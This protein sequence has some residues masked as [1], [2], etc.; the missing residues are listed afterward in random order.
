M[1]QI[2]VSD[3]LKNVLDKQG[4]DDDDKQIIKALQEAYR[5][6]N[7]RRVQV[8]YVAKRDVLDLMRHVI[9]GTTGQLRQ[10]CMPQPA[11]PTDARITECDWDYQRACWAFK[12]WSSEFPIVGENTLLPELGLAR[13]DLAQEREC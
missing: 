8:L 6:T 10:F 9:A 1:A 3:W 11:I 5:Y 2:D 13:F 4:V 7:E 12:V